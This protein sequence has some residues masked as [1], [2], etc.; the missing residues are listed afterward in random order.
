MKRSNPSNITMTQ[1]VQWQML[2]HT[3]KL[4]YKTFHYILLTGDSVTGSTSHRADKTVF[5]QLLKS[6]RERET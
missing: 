5:D 3:P 4:I 1:K 6:G 2:Y